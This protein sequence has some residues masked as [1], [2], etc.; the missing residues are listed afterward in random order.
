MVDFG[1]VPIKAIWLRK[2]GKDEVE[3]LIE[4]RGGW[5]VVG[6]EYYPTENEVSHIWELAALRNA[7]PDVVTHS[8]G[9]GLK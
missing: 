5:N 6:K 7:K 2:K 4:T 9:E 3:I 8:T 1:N